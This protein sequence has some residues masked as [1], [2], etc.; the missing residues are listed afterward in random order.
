MKSSI[1]KALIDIKEEDTIANVEFETVTTIVA[2]LMLNVIPEFFGRKYEAAAVTVD[3]SR[4]PGK[5]FVVR[6]ARMREREIR[7]RIF[8]QE[9]QSISNSSYSE[10]KSM[11]ILKEKPLTFDEKLEKAIYSKTKVLYCSTKKSTSF[12]KIRNQELFDSIKNPSPN[13]IKLCKALKT[14]PPTSVK[15]ERAFSAAGLF[16]TELRTTL[17]DKSINGLNP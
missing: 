14:S 17:S 7:T 2:G 5:N 1:L 15:A 11:E 12:N 9:Q 6:Q 16:N 8:C 13:I 4:L 10:E 3:I